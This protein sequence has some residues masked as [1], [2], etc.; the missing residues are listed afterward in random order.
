MSGERP[1]RHSGHTRPFLP[2]K[3]SSAAANAVRRMT[4][5]SQIA[6]SAWPLQQPTPSSIARRGCDCVQQHRCRPPHPPL[7]KPDKPFPR[8]LV[9]ALVALIACDN[10]P[11]SVSATQEALSA[12]QDNLRELDAL[13]RAAAAPFSA[14]QTLQE[15]EAQRDNL[16]A[17]AAVNNVSAPPGS[18]FQR[19]SYDCVLHAGQAQVPH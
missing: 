5:R 2:Q 12:I 7:C 19:Q 8:Q 1:L 17:Q 6:A 16:A 18:S 15:L 13:C 4:A 10:P 3:N 11:P 14:S 9:Q